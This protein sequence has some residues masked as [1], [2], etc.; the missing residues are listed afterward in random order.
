MISGIYQIYNKVNGKCYIGS[1]KSIEKRI[2]EHYRDLR[3]NRHCNRYLQR[4]WNKYGSSIFGHKILAKCPEEYLLKLE[5][6]FI[7]NYSNLYNLSPTAGRLTGYK[8]TIESKQKISLS[9]KGNIRSKGRILTEEHKSKV[10]NSEG[11]ISFMKNKQRAV[12]QLD[13]KGN[14]INTFESV[15]EC[16]RILN[17]DQGTISK[18]CLGKKGY[19]SYKGF[20]FEY[21]GI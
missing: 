19:K 18:I 17:L 6:W 15:T 1:S 8:H 21:M 20:V 9:L 10:F 13:K 11:Y 2:G 12:V 3:A 5:Q 16:S 14:Q 7:D 4:V